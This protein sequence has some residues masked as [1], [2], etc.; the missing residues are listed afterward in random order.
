[1]GKK[2]KV[3]ERRGV[4]SPFGQLYTSLTCS[5]LTFHW[6]IFDDTFLCVDILIVLMLIHN[7]L[8]AD[9]LLD[10]LMLMNT[11]LCVDFLFVYCLYLALC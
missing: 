3:R 10:V 1:V 7:L 6:F 2:Y 8:C 11:L 4:N 5:V 9:L